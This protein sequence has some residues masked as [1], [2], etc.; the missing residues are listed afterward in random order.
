[1]DEILFHFDVF[2]I[3]YREACKSECARQILQVFC[4]RLSQNYG[5]RALDSIAEDETPQGKTVPLCISRD[6]L[7]T[8][9]IYE[10]LDADNRPFQQLDVRFPL[11]VN[12]FFEGK[13]L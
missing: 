8:S 1:M 2:V 12:F 4:D 11:E 9:A 6:G 7:F 13:Q 3:V 10:V 5:A